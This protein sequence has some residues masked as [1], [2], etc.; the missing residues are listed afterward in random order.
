MFSSFFQGYLLHGRKV[1]FLIELRGAVPVTCVLTS[2][3]GRPL[4]GKE[5]GSVPLPKDTDRVVQTLFCS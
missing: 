5:P 2:G 3:L 1:I 4:V